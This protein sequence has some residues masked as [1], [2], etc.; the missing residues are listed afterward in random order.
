[1]S[2]SDL[3]DN[4]TGTFEGGLEELARNTVGDAVEQARADSRAF[5]ERSRESLRRWGDALAQGT[6]SK[7]DF[8]FLVRGQKDL[9][10]MHALKAVGLAVT[11][12][13]RFRTGLLS[14]I[15]NSVFTTV[16]L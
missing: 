3:W 9:A 15:V 13:E 5:L 12:I 4:F 10:Q 2:F 11:K 6:I 7:D 8:E 14:L 16:G 1:M